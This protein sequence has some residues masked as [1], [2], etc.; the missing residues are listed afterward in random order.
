MVLAGLTFGLSF[1][2]LGVA[3][4]PVALTIAAAKAVLVILFFMELADSRAT[5]RF[6]MA[7]ALLL[8]I[9]LLS[10]AA[11]DVLT[12]MVPVLPPGWG[13]KASQNSRFEA[14]S[15]AGV[16]SPSRNSELADRHLGRTQR[17]IRNPY[18]TKQALVETLVPLAPGQFLL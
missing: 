1:L 8:L 9:I 2:H 18:W 12:H 5:P 3:A 11:A 10:L 15:S 17:L 4:A 16:L 14:R 7:V 6:A 13:G